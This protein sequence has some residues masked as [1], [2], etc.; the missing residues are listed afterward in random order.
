MDD[1]PG[2][3]AAG[4]GGAGGK[5]K[6]PASPLDADDA[7]PPAVGAGLRAGPGG[8]AGAVAL[9]AGLV[10][11][12]VDLFLTAEGRFLEGQLQAGPEGLA[13]LGAGPAA[14]GAA[15]EAEPAKAAQQIA[16]AQDP[17]RAAIASQETAALYGL[18]VLEAN[19]NQSSLNTT[20]FAVLSRVENDQER[21][22]ADDRFIMVFTVR[23][24]AGSLAEAIQIIGSHGFNMRVLRSRAMKG[25]L[26]QYYMFVEGEG[27]IHSDAGREM[28]AELKYLG[29]PETE[30]L[31]LVR[32]GEN[33]D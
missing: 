28:L 7:G 3:L 9:L 31:A 25:L 27:A 4:T 1:L 23:N 22:G 21:T 16:Q 11:V 14:G 20:R 29:V 2:P 30:L 13:L 8:A 6:G 5:G 32:E 24:E 26:W 19:I 12:E 15:P 10:P 18:E 17:A 33:D